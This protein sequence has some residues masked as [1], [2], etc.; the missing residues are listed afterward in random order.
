MTLELLTGGAYL[1]HLVLRNITMH[2]LKQSSVTPGV[3]EWGTSL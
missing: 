3:L 2:D 1:G